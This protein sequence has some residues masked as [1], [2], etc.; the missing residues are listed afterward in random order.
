MG[1]TKGQIDLDFFFPQTLDVKPGDTVTWTFS[2]EDVAPHT[3]TFLNGADEPTP[4]QAV[5]QPSG[6]P[7]LTFNPAVAI[8]QNADKPLTNMGIFNSGIL[9]P[10]A[11]GP[12]DF[13][14]KIGN[15]AGALAY[16]CILHD[17]IGMTGTLNVAQ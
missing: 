8:P 1:Y 17:D 13:T 11:P 6:P 3:I 15:Y 14:L 9:D 16:R 7:L 10:T 5:P 4:I 2:K 12:H